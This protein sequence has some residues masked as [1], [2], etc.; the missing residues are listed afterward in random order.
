[1]SRPSWT[2]ACCP[3]CWDDRNPGRQPVVVKTREPEICCYCGGETSDGI[4]VRVDPS[5]VPHPV[6]Q[7]EDD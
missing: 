3:E 7:K 1:M 6:R 2:Q 4:F 5:T